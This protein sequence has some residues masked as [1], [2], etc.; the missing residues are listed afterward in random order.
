VGVVFVVLMAARAFIVY[1]IGILGKI[2][3]FEWLKIPPAWQHITYWGGM[4][5]AVPVALALGLPL[6]LP[7]RGALVGIIFGVVLLSLLGQGLSMP[8]LLEKLKLSKST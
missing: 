1:G 3:P 2:K 8:I 7:G 4:R 5:G 6:K